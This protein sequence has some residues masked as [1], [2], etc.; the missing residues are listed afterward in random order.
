MTSS[1]SNSYGGYGTST[2]THERA[3]GGIGMGGLADDNSVLPVP[4]HV[5][6]HHLGTSAI[7]NGVLA[8]ADTVRYKKKVGSSELIN[9]YWEMMILIMIFSIL[10]R[11]IISR[12]DYRFVDWDE[13]EGEIT[14]RDHGQS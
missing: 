14:G 13:G 7:R 4:S 1:G 2:S 5:V 12:L 9:K 8:V 3:Y 10:R 6:L 11:F